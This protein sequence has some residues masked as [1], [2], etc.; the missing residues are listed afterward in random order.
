M[1]TLS[2]LW[3]LACQLRNLIRIGIV[4]D[5]DTAQALCRLETG[6]ITTDLLHWLTPR[7]GHS[8]TWWVPSIGEQVLLLAIGGELDTAFVLSGIYPDDNPAPSA[9]ADVLHI[10][11]P[12]AA[13]MEYEPKTGALTVSFRV[14]KLPRS[15]HPNLW[16]SRC[17]W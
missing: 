15:R 1:N 14:L 7:A 2:S 17:R 5:V 6:G 10:S 8:R 4:T 9:S 3:D 12:D 13:V 11:F 16:L